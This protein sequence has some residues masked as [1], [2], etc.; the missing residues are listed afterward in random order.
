[1][2]KILTILIISLMFVSA[3][4]QTDEEYR[5]E[6]GAGVG[7]V[8]YEGDFNGSVL[9][10]MQF[11]GSVVLRRVFNPYMGLKMSAMYGKLTGASKD[12]KTYYPDFVNNPYSFSNTLID[13]S[14]TYE[15]NFW[16]YGTGRDY[17][18]AKRFTPFI[19][20]G[21][22]ATFVTGG[23]KNVFTANLPLG[24]GVKYK[25]E[26]RTRMGSTLLAERQTRRRERPL[27]HRKQ[28]TLQ[29][30]R[31]LLSPTTHADVQLHGEMP[32]LPQ[33]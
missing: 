23:G 11:G 15:Y 30:H 5:M 18:G 14:V 10:N 9:S 26:P 3:K 2:K 32:H 29:K 17:R 28:R 13:A 24:L 16:P 8:A 7:M 27:R 22:G 12:V 31:L 21:L 25:S 19:F 33:R 1:M 20:G 4:A 6:I